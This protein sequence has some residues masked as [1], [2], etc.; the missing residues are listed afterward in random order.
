[1]SKYRVMLV[2]K[3]TGHSFFL[4]R[5]R[6]GMNFDP[7]EWVGNQV[8]TYTDEDAAIHDAKRITPI[9][10]LQKHFLYI[11]RYYKESASSE[12]GWYADLE[13]THAAFAKKNPGM[14]TV[15]NTLLE[16]VERPAWRMRLRDKISGNV[17]STRANH[18]NDA[19]VNIYWKRGKK[20]AHRAYV[21]YLN[22]K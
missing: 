19:L 3:K 1:M 18:D 5:S 6:A 21:K 13:L 17:L 4:C 22:S 11:T 12:E 2:G 9:D 8:I 16:I 7:V 14:Y 20:A 10:A 15:A